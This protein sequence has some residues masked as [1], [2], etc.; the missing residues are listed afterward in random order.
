M[1]VEANFFKL[2]HLLT[3]WPFEVDHLDAIMLLSKAPGQWYDD[4]V[5]IPFCLLVPKP[6]RHTGA[7]PPEHLVPETRVLRLLPAFD[8]HPRPFVLGSL[9]HCICT[10]HDVPRRV[11]LAHRTTLP[12]RVNRTAHRTDVPCRS[13]M[14]MARRCRGEPTSL[15]IAI[16]FRGEH[17]IHIARR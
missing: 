15:H 17:F 13:G 14:K 12:W 5:P 1:S 16:T 9:G 2:P 8:A 3:G 10:S 7:G 4:W 6:A 11:L